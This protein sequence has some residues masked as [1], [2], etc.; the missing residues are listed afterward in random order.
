MDYSKVKLCL[1]CVTAPELRCV[2]I[3]KS[4]R[5]KTTLTNFITRGNNASHLVMPK[6]TVAYGE[7]RR[8]VLTVVETSDVFSL[9]RDKIRHEMRKCVALCPPGPNVLL[10]LATSSGFNEEDRQKLK[11][12]LS[13]FGEDAFKYSMVIEARNEEVPSSSITETIQ[14]CTY[15]HHRIDFNKKTLSED[16]Y[17]VLLEKMEDIVILNKGGHL[18]CTECCDPTPVSADSDPPVNLVLCGRFQAW[19]T[20]AT[21]AILGESKFDDPLKSGKIQGQVGGRL[22][23][24]VKLPALHGRP[25][26]SIQRESLQCVSQ[27]DPEGIHAFMLVLPVGPITEEDEEELQTIQNVFSSRVNGFTMVLLTVRS[28]P[29]SPDVV[30]FLRE[31]RH[32]NQLCRS[33]QGRY[34]VFDLQDKQQVFELL[35]GVE[36]IRAGAP[37][38]F[39]KDMMAKHR[40]RK[41][42]SN[43]SY[44][45]PLKAVPNK[46]CLRIVMIGKTGCGKSAT[47]NTILNKP[48]FKSTPCL[49]SVTKLCQ[50]VTGDVDGQPVTVVDTPGLYDTSLSN[51]QV[52]KELVNCITLL[53]PGPHVFLLVIKIGRFTEEER[54]TVDLIM[55]FFGRKSKDFTIVLFTGGD[56]LNHDQTIETFIQ[57]DKAGHLKQLIADCSGRYLVFN[58]VDKNRGQV[59]ELVSM[60]KSMI[61]ANGNTCYTSEIFQEAEAAI[62]KEANRILMENMDKIWREEEE[63]RR[64]HKN[65]IQAKKSELEKQISLIEQERHEKTKLFQQKE[66]YI[67]WEQEKIK[68]EEEETKAKETEAKRDEEIQR[69]NWRQILEDMDNNF[70]RNAADKEL[71]RNVEAVRQD[72]E[73]WEQERQEWWEK[74]YHEDHQRLLAEKAKLKNLIKEHEQEIQLYINKRKEAQVRRDEE[75]KVLCKLQDEL[76][77]TVVAIRSKHEEEA[78]KQAEKINEFQQKYIKDFAALTERH[79]EEVQN[80]KEKQQQQNEFLIRRLSKYCRKDFENLKKR[81]EEEMDELTRTFDPMYDGDLIVAISELEITHEKEIKDWIQVQMEKQR[82]KNCVIL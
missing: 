5:D 29:N 71:K 34:F 32:V 51:D 49:E 82:N 33:C 64:K 81:H 28:D 57:N 48:C 41:P 20:S 75:Q 4:Q 38:G 76:E 22:V 24:V 21:T 25:Q 2:L 16:D 31:N 63:V 54:N 36:K 30:K 39:T 72:K 59:R 27:C 46:E 70:K 9:P 26:E 43:L 68:R 53:A 1:F 37:K 60:V 65:E 58:N 23:S 55:E 35:Q 13:F 44:T 3:G 74:R 8:K 19:K 50:K 47:G 79:D 14:D 67:E 40:S 78:R 6:C 17:Q 61:K 66:E 42:E 77:D 62:Q 10:L 80:W 56:S 12:I 52:K 11:F 18:N 15:R 45:E 69:T 73:I 7:W